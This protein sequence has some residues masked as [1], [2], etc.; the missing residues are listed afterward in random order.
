MREWIRRSTPSS[1][2]AGF[3]LRLPNFFSPSQ[4]ACSQVSGGIIEI[5]IIDLTIDF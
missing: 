4:G 1:F 2:A 3:T 5:G